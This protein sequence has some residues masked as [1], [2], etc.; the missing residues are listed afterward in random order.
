MAYL[1]TDCKME[2]FCKY[3]HRMGTVQMEDKVACLHTA[4]ILDIVTEAQHQ[5]SSYS[6]ESEFNL[7]LYFVL[8]G[9]YM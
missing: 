2:V 6:L 4:K 8:E 3:K 7:V 5:T 9:Y 1:Y